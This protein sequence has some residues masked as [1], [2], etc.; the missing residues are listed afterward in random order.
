M[1]PNISFDNLLNP[2]DLG[3]ELSDAVINLNEFLFNP[4]FSINTDMEES[5]HHDNA[6]T[7]THNVEISSALASADLSDNDTYS[8][9]GVSNSAQTPTA[10][11]PD[12]STSSFCEI[13]PTYS[14]A[15]KVTY[16]TLNTMVR[17]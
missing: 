8:Y 2:T 14:C 4:N 3:D 10:G 15:N 11:P 5:E 12:E 7:R 9:V 1:E 13:Q 16:Q 6:E 17:I